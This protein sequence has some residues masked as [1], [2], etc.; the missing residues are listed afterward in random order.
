[1][2]AQRRPPDALLAIFL[3]AAAAPPDGVPADPVGNLLIDDDTFG[4]LLVE[5]GLAAPRH[6]PGW[7]S[8]LERRCETVSGVPIHLRTALAVLVEGR[9]RRVVCDG[10]GV[11]VN[12]GRTQRRSPA[13]PGRWCCSRPRGAGGRAARCRTAD[14]RPT[15]SSRGRPGKDEP[16]WPTVTGCAVG[17]TA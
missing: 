7:P 13:R 1:M 8:T 3:V 16:T 5:A 4:E 9:V 2:L 10:N 6:E 15:T 12:L 11:V 14:F 17:T